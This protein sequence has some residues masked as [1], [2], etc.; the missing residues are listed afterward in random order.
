MFRQLLKSY[1]INE[2]QK[3]GDIAKNLTRYL[4]ELKSVLEKD[5]M[6]EVNNFLKNI[7]IL[8]LELQV[9]QQQ[10]NLKKILR[11]GFLVFL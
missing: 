9:L 7:L 2:N 8:T 6:N 1:P 5:F 4:D 3:L 11:K 10:L